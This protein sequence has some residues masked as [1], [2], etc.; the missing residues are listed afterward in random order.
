MGP[1]DDEIEFSLGA[2]N[3]NGT[4]NVLFYLGKGEDTVV[5]S[6]PQGF[7]NNPV[8]K[9]I[10][11]FN[12]QE[13]EI[14]LKNAELGGR[15]WE[16]V[17]V[18]GD[19][20]I[21]SVNP[22]GPLNPVDSIVLKNINA[23]TLSFTDTGE[24]IVVG[25]GDT[26]PAGPVE[27]DVQ[28]GT[29]GADVLFGNP[30]SNVLVGL[31]GDDTLISFENDDVLL[32]G[33]GNDSLDGGQGGDQLFGGTGND[34]LFG[35]EGND[36]LFGGEGDDFLV[37]GDGV[38]GLFTGEGSDVVFA[39]AG[40]DY[41]EAAGGANDLYG[42]AGND[43]IVG[44][45]GHDSIHGG[46]GDD[47]ILGG[48]ASDALWGGSGNDIIDGGEG[49]NV[50]YGDEGND[51]L[52]NGEILRGGDG[53]DVLI[54]AGFAALGEAGDDYFAGATDGV[55]ITTGSGHDLVKLETEASHHT[56]TDF[57][58]GVDRVDA[59]F[60]F[61]AAGSSFLDTV[62][63]REQGGDILI[64]YLE[65]SLLLQNMAYDQI[66]AEDFLLAEDVEFS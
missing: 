56:V 14:I 20:V 59:T 65:A 27:E 60:I 13:D 18:E 63:I 9:T 21:R 35:A 5:Q 44:G 55:L 8:A 22:S 50:L 58:D 33:E 28:F 48:A 36:V 31:E 7:P 54:S 4:Q 64:E 3:L 11:D 1:G 52:Y 45:D 49:T 61:I 6:G 32:G 43:E 24:T 17:D 42:E 53:N 10:L 25:A 34:E 30:F 29:D 46:E 15:V 39:G 2:F 51:V 57:E 12:P 47:L 26:G 37:G 66:E 40:D 23:E 19:A 62:G 41:I 16:I 38:D